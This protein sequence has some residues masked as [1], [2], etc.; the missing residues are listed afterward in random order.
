MEDRTT[1]LLEAVRE[2]RKWQKEYF[3]SRRSEALERSKE[4]ERRVDELLRGW[5]QQKLF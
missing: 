1:E 5:E 4:C 3:R 2:M